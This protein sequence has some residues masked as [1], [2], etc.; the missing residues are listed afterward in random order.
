MNE[1][2]PRQHPDHGRV[3]YQLEAI[4]EDGVVWRTTVRV[5]IAGLQRLTERVLARGKPM[6]LGGA[7]AVQVLK[8]ARTAVAAP[9]PYRSEEE[10][11]GA[12]RTEGADS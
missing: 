1:D 8:T 12:S 9:S 4:D 2:D 5:D 11:R 7:F 10:E 3:I 6:R